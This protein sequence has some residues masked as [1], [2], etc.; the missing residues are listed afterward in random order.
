[1]NTS[2]VSIRSMRNCSDRIRSPSLGKVEECFWRR[3][4]LPEGPQ[5][6]RV[7]AERLTQ[8]HKSCP[9]KEDESFEHKPGI[10]TIHGKWIL[11]D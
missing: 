9:V 3:S 10:S 11:S 5:G 8:L 7:V 1:M 6:F 4:K 2:L